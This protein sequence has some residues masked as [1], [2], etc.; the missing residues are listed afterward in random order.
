MFQNIQNSCKL[1]HMLLVVLQCSNLLGSQWKGVR[2][3]NLDPERT[4]KTTKPKQKS[5]RTW[6]KPKSRESGSLCSRT[7]TVYTYLTMVGSNKGRKEPRQRRKS[8]LCCVLNLR[9]LKAGLFERSKPGS[10]CSW[11]IRGCRIWEF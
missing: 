5:S 9:V 4:N 11:I 2:S 8:N 10:S 1:F 7:I 3:A 6:T